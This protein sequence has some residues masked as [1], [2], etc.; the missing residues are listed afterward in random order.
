MGFQLSN[1]GPIITNAQRV[2]GRQG[3][4]GQSTE[5][6]LLEI[7][8][9]ERAITGT[10]SHDISNTRDETE[11]LTLRQMY[12]SD[13]EAYANA[14]SRLTFQ[15]IQE[16]GFENIHGHRAICFMSLQTGMSRNEVVRDLRQAYNQTMEMLRM[17]RRSSD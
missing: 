11:N 7:R 3:R 12:A 9:C 4:Q 6:Q 16:L 13:M 14:F 15:D 17:G 8:A 1:H 10:S 2:T 5:Q